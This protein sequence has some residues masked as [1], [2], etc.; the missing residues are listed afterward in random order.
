[1]CP[2]VVTLLDLVGDVASDSPVISRSLLVRSSV[3]VHCAG[4][5]REPRVSTAST[6]WPVGLG[7]VAT[8]V[9]AAT[10]MLVKVSVVNGGTPSGEGRW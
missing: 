6:V 5:S 10:L 2:V 7:V 1:M 8:V 3:P 4:R 9:P